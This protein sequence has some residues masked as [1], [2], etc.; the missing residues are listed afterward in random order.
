MLHQA[1]CWLGLV[2]QTTESP[3][4]LLFGLQRFIRRE[5]RLQEVISAGPWET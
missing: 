3:L 5:A 1:A 4:S 2:T